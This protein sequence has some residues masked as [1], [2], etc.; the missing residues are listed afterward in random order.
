MVLPPPLAEVFDERHHSFGPGVLSHWLPKLPEV[1]LINH[2]AGARASTGA[3]LDTCVKMKALSE[4]SSGAVALLF[5]GPLTRF[6]LW[7]GSSRCA[8]ETAQVLR[9][10]YVLGAEADLNWWPTLIETRFCP[11]MWVG[12]ERPPGHPMT[13]YGFVRGTVGVPYVP[14]MHTRKED[15]LQAALA[16]LRAAPRSRLATIFAP[17][18]PRHDPYSKAMNSFRLRLADR[19]R[20]F[21]D[22]ACRDLT[23][24]RPLPNTSLVS[25]LVESY[26]DAEFCLMP[27][28][29][30]PT[31]G[32]IFD[33][34]CALCI[35]VFFSSCV[36]GGD[37]AY[38]LMYH[39]FLP[40]HERTSWGVGDWAV[41]LNMNDAHSD[42]LEQGLRNI[43]SDAK[44]ALR[45]RI[46]QLVPRI[47]FAD[48][49]N[50][51]AVSAGRVY[52]DLMAKLARERG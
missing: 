8:N 6:H 29:D 51:T 40:R 5:E 28:G 27:Q 48:P 13:G 50:A 34:L 42:A 9:Q 19:C 26:A 30:C 16:H 41:V 46:S 3:G 32:A 14:W 39:P 21:A 45:E 31:R 2:N 44:R 17:T 4:D 23:H 24:D 47:Q 43:S 18:H 22:K 52:A 12:V 15:D 35:P 38:E 20:G 36:P 1:Q 11:R 10:L 49:W 33:A 37:L 7:S 25:W